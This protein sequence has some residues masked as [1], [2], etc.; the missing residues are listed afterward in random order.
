[1]S[2]ATPRADGSGPPRVAVTG[3]TGL[4][5]S[6]LGDLL[7][8]NGRRVHRVTRSPE[9]GSDDIGWDPAAGHLEVGALEG[10][11]ALVN[12]AGEPVFGLRWTESKKR[13]IRESRL[14]GTRLLAE[15]AAAL[16]R[17][18][19]VLVSASAIGYY[20]DRGAARLVESDP[21]GEGFLADLCREWEA[22]TAP[23]EKAGVRVVHLRIGLVLS[24][25]G[26]AL[27]T[28]LPAFKLGAGGR[29]GSGEQYMSWIALEDLIATIAFALE[30]DD[31]RG[32]ANATAPAPVTNAEFTR[33][34]GRVLRRPTPLPVPAF[35]LRLALGELAEE[36][37]LASARVEPAALSAAGFGFR[38]ATLE[39]ALRAAL[40]LS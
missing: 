1:M 22:A 20:G 12:L 15:R 10:V 38:H 27:A 33:T 8:A 29:L 14:R 16:A 31:L 26:G 3:A 13:A 5:G 36:M 28:M 39:A 7:R 9:P 21:P 4:V 25:E 18:P 24:R 11:D 6:A 23:A 30:R 37:L 17:P 19:R 34:L 2:G 35:A 32:A 40:G